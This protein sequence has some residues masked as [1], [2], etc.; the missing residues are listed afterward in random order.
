MVP[1]QYFTT[2]EELLVSLKTAQ[3]D[4]FEL[5]PKMYLTNTRQNLST[6][7][8]VYLTQKIT[9]YNLFCKNV[10]PYTSHMCKV[11]I[12][13]QF[14]RQFLITNSCF[15]LV[16]ILLRKFDNSSKKKEK[17]KKEMKMIKT[18]FVI[19]NNKKGHK[20]FKNLL[21]LGPKTIHVPHFE[22]IG[23]LLKNPK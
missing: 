9:R 15:W 4:S 2:R 11:F 21:N 6:I 1:G 13:V 8:S 3:L 5:T 10:L 20:S 18:N 7:F 12:D 17:K 14:H 16:D 23:I 22:Q 19:K